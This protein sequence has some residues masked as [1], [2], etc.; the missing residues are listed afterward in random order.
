[1]DTVAVEK[2]YELAEKWKASGRRTLILRIYAFGVV[3]SSMH[4]RFNGNDS[5]FGKPEVGIP[6]HS[7]TY[8]RKVTFTDRGVRRSLIF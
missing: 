1:M 7:H 5:K 4:Q 8:N 3:K 2:R 6:L